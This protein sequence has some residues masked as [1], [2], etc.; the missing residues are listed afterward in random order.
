[1]HNNPAWEDED[2][3]QVWRLKIYA[4]ENDPDELLRRMGED[5]PQSLKLKEKRV[6]AGRVPAE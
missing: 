3:G 6:S 5:F 1:M 2:G 4:M